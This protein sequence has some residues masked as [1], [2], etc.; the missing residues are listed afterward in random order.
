VELGWPLTDDVPAELM[1]EVS[2]WTEERLSPLARIVN[3]RTAYEL[4]DASGA[5]VAEFVND[6]VKASDLR[7][8]VDREWCEWEVELG[9]AAPE[10]HE[11]FFAEIEKIALEAGATR[12][13]S[14]SKLARALGR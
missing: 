10:D 3:D 2:Q 6:R 8:G 11:A 5:V 14:A 7:R 1:A 13:S 4:L 9:P 12:P